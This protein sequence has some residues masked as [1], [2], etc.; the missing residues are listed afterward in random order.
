MAC[1]GVVLFTGPI[2][3][4]LGTVF[5]MIQAFNRV[6]G[7]GNVASVDL[8]NHVRLALNSTVIGI[9]VGLMGGA[10]ILASI[11]LTGYRKKW[12]YSWS[13][14]LAIIWCIAL[15]PIGLIIALPFISLFKTR[16]REFERQKAEQD[17]PSDGDK[18][19]V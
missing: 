10:L 15:F 9:V 6:S 3:G 5:G 18:H 17:A 11:L 2:W 12:F 7:G 14:G 13:L 8:S 16:R 1:I 4:F 19:S